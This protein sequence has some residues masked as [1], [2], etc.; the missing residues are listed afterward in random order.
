M[1]SIENDSATTSSHEICVYSS[2][3]FKPNRS[4]KR[5]TSTNNA[6][7][8][9]TRLR[10]AHTEYYHF[11]V[12]YVRCRDILDLYPVCSLLPFFFIPPTYKHP[13]SQG[14][15]CNPLPACGLCLGF[16]VREEFSPSLYL[17]SLGGLNSWFLRFWCIY[18]G[19]HRII[20]REIRAP[21]VTLKTEAI[22]KATG[23]LLMKGIRAKCQPWSKPT[24]PFQGPY[25]IWY[26]CCCTIDIISCN[27]Q[28]VRML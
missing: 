5:S 21:T 28:Q 26:L 1:S 13:G 19:N 12:M 22:H 8:L 14:R 27:R 3:F 17:L 4:W 2:V 20:H 7:F 9:R 6:V 25:Y 18:C 11:V 23:G 16:I 15:H 24:K 10:N